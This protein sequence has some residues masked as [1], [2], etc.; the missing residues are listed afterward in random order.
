MGYL[1]FGLGR[2]LM[3]IFFGELLGGLL[4]SFVFLGD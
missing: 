1:W 2:F 4:L 3:G